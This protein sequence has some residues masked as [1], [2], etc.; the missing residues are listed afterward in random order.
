MRLSASILTS[1]RLSTIYGH[2]EGNR[3]LKLIADT[4]NRNLQDGEHLPE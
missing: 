3:V 1:S 2:D 4:V